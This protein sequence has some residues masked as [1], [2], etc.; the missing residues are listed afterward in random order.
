VGANSSPKTDQ[1]CRLGSC[2]NC[3]LYF[4]VVPQDEGFPL[5]FTHYLVVTSLTPLSI[6]MRIS[7]IYSRGPSA[8]YT[9]FLPHSWAIEGYTLSGYSSWYMR[10]PA[11]YS[12]SRQKKQIVVGD[13][14][15]LPR[16]KLWGWERLTNPRE[17]IGLPLGILEWVTQNPPHKPTKK[18]GWIPVQR[19]AFPIICVRRTCNLIRCWSLEPCP[20]FP[21]PHSWA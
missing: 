14:P 2:I 19:A 6:R 8:S 18:L 4:A 13:V 11:L 17:Y 9:G 1:K 20:V 3:R 10:G 5:R 16:R 15:P 7:S 12:P 21:L